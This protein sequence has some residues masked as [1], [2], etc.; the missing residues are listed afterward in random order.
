[1]MEAIFLWNWT[2]NIFWQYKSFYRN[3]EEKRVGKRLYKISAQP[4]CRNA[5]ISLKEAQNKAKIELSL[6]MISKHALL[7]L[8]MP[9]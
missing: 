8:L 6:D 9:D 3:I 7:Y 2:W 5:L 1:M 4:A